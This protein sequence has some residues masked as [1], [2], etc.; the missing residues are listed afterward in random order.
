MG[1]CDIYMKIILITQEQIYS[2]ILSRAAR[3]IPKGLTSYVK[4]VYET[5]WQLVLDLF[6][7]KRPMDGINARQQQFRMDL[8]HIDHNVNIVIL[9]SVTIVLH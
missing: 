1:I 9:Y 2:S 5:V 4:C 3:E 8:P 7:Q 6:I